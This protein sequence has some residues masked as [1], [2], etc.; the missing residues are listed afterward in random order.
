VLVAALNTVPSMSNHAACVVNM[1]IFPA[2]FA[3]L[4]HFI[5]KLFNLT[6]FCILFANLTHLVAL[7]AFDHTFSIAAIAPVPAHHVTTHTATVM[8]ISVAISQASLAFSSLA[9]RNQYQIMSL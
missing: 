7:A 3:I 5:H 9:F 1:D 6:S 4:N 8:A 2:V